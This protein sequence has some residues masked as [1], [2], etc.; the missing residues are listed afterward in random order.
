MV[1]LMKFLA[2]GLHMPHIK[3]LYLTITKFYSVTD[4][5]IDVISLTIVYTC[6]S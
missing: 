2:Q 5:K 6:T 4:K 3:V 1:L